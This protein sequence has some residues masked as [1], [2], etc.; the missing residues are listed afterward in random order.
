MKPAWDFGPP[1]TMAPSCGFPA[2]LNPA[3]SR[4]VPVSLMNSST[5]QYWTLRIRATVAA[6]SVMNADASA[7]ENAPWPM[8]A[9]AS[10]MP[11][12]SAGGASAVPGFTGFTG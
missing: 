11:V 8:A 2:Q 3:N 4:K 12:C 9:S 7:S 5:L 10:R 6:A 1:S